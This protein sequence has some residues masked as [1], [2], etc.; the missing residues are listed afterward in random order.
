MLLNKP[1]TV[2]CLEQL[3]HTIADLDALRAIHVT[4]SKGKGSTCAFTE[5]ML[6]SLGLKT[7]FYSSPHVLQHREMIRIDGA[8]LSEEK[9][10][11][12]V[13]AAYDQLEKV[14]QAVEICDPSP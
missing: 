10:A 5:A 2:S 3:G 1:R 11:D 8:P 4:G 13:I 14:D 7:G 6:R 12:E 9:F